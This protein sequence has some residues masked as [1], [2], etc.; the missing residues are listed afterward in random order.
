MRARYA[1]KARV[2]LHSHILK[3]GIDTGTKRENLHYCLDIIKLKIN[4]ILTI[5]GIRKCGKT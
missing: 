1:L 4:K 3:K 5:F 2:E